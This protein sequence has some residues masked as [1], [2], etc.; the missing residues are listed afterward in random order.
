MYVCKYI[1]ESGLPQK[2]IAYR[3][4]WPDL[5]KLRV[6]VWLMQKFW[7]TNGVPRSIKLEPNFTFNTEQARSC[8]I[9]NLLLSNNLILS[10]I[11]CSALSD[12]ILM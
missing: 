7:I 1:N 3:F 4:T 11:P 5:I 10:F 9:M 8:F 6:T 12:A 2:I